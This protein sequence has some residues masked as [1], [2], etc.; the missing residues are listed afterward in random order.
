MI[1]DRQEV[2]MEALHWNKS[3]NRIDC[4]PSCDSLYCNVAPCVVQK[5][6]AMEFA[7]AADNNQVWLFDNFQTPYSFKRIFV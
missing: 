6:V 4:A 2:Y 1:A 5:I 7:K 3:H